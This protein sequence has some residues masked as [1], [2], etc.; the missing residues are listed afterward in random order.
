MTF[1][2]YLSWFCHLSP[3]AIRAL[4]SA[5]TKCS[6]T[7]SLTRTQNHLVV[8][9]WC[10]APLGGASKALQWAQMR[11]MVILLNL[12]FLLM[13]MGSN[14]SWSTALAASFAG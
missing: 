8:L 4:G 5:P 7:S 13:M 10:H 12:D 14:V 9:L 11:S 6:A 3:A 1:I 2:Q